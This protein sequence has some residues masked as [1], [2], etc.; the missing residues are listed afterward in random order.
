[1]AELLNE[2]ERGYLFGLF[3]GDGYKYHDKKS[4]HYHVEFYLNSLR[5]KKIISFLVCLL[6]KNMLNPSIYLDKRY[7][8]KRIRVY[9]KSFFEIISKNI[10][11]HNKSKE[12]NIGFVSG[13]ID[14][15]G[16]VNNKKHYIMV[17]N[18]NKKMLISCKKFLE[19]IGILSSISKRTR[20]IKDKLDSYRMYIS[21][22][23]KRL[24]HVSIKAGMVLG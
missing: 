11:I 24:N 13:L 2:K 12:F 5:D 19:S 1:M 21:V 9:N 16:Y 15:E 3:E 18:T 10:E 8:C 22:N 7:N 6:K 14:S 20:S 4:R 23:F 17:I